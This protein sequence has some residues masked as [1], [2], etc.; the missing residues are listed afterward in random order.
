MLSASGVRLLQG[1]EGFERQ[2]YQDSGGIWTVGYGH[3]GPNVRRG[4]RVTAA[5]AAQLLRADVRW[6]AKAVDRLVKAPINRNRRDALIIFVYNVGEAAFAS[7]TLLRLLN[8]GAYGAA[9]KQFA[10]W[11]KVQGRAID[12]L[13]NRRKIERRLF[14]RPVA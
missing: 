9:S 5:R 14:D 1:L 3:T 4:T 8:S 11:N 10:R 13:T 7:S 12:G 6:A 2:A